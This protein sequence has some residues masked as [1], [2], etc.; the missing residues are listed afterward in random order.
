MI[1]NHDAALDGGRFVAVD[2]ADP[3]AVGPASNE[4]Y[5]EMTAEFEMLT[6]H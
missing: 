1:K 6:V 4:V 2:A 5:D 3:L